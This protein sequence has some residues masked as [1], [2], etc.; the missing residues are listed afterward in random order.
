MNCILAVA[1]FKFQQVLST[2]LQ[3]IRLFSVKD[4]FL[5]R[6]LLTWPS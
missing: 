3:Q 2:L 6:G 5:I 4:N 1:R